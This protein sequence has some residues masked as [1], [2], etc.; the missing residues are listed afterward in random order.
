MEEEINYSRAMLRG[1]QSLPRKKFASL[2]RVGKVV[3]RR[4]Q[5]LNDGKKLRAESS[6]IKVDNKSIA[7][8]NVCLLIPEQMTIAAL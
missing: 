2:H 1:C 4:R 6:R 8:R 7:N 5:V 3:R